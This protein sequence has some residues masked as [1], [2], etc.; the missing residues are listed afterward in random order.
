VKPELTAKDE[1]LRQRL[2]E[3]GSVLVAYSGGVDS[4]LLARLAFEELGQ[5]AVAVTAKS[6]TY[7]PREFDEARELAEQIG[8]RHV[9]VETSEFNNDNFTSNPPD[10]CYHCKKELFGQLAQVAKAEGLEHVVDGSNADDT[11]DYR[12]GTQ[13][14]AEFAVVSPLQE[15]GFTK[16]DIRELSREMGLS[17]HDKP[18]LACLATR[19][20][21]GTEITKEAL[22]Q[23]AQAEEAIR[24]LGFRQVRV[25]HHG[26]LA[27]VEVEP[28]D[29]SRIMELE[30]S[31]RISEALHRLGYVYISVDIDG[32]R[33]GSMNETLR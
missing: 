7:P 31:D 17:T 32:Y 2:R 5:K 8:I 25:R 12:P 9:I 18:A 14:A 29:V 3:L 33:T 15:A 16:E 6:P 22:E 24:A 21:Y 28:T 20:P 13:A 23:V 11:E 27:R 30:T 26:G 10:R 4:T 19:F 1:K